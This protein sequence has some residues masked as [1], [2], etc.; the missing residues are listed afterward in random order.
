MVNMGETKVKLTS[1]MVKIITEEADVDVY[2]SLNEAVR[3]ALR[4]QKQEE[5]LE[6]EMSSILRREITIGLGDATAGRISRKSVKDIA[7]EV[8]REPLGK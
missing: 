4:P 7:E 5:P 1:C 6:I 8:R 3:E 2:S